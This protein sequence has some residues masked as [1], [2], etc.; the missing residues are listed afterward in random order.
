MVNQKQQFTIERRVATMSFWDQLFRKEGS[1][2]SDSTAKAKRI[3]IKLSD[4]NLYGVC[5]KCRNYG[6]PKK[7][8]E[9]EYRV[10][11]GTC[12]IGLCAA[13]AKWGYVIEDS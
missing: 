5:S 12:Y 2:T 11:N 7:I 9:Y 3:P 8:A 6:S 4:P 10:S 1:K 13:H